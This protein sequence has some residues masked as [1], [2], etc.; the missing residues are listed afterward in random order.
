MESTLILVVILAVSIIG[1]ASSVSVATCLLL[2]IKLLHAD[3][4]IYPVIEKNGMFLGLVIL[5]AAILIPIANGNITIINI[6]NVLTSWIGLTAIILSFFTTYISGLGFQFLSVQNHSDI[7]TSL[8]IGAVAA[9]A[10]LG[11]VPVGP[12]ITSGILA[13]IV[14]AFNN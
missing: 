7:M 1:K 14:K 10:L 11:G 2:M 8:I 12:L 5:I 6:R 3:H 4:Y 9:A 13:I